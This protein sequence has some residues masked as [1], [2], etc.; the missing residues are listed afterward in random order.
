VIIDDIIW[1][2]LFSLLMIGF[3][4]YMMTMPGKSYCGGLPKLSSAQLSLQ[5]A[6][7][8]HVNHLALTI[9]ERNAWQYTNLVA[10]KHYIEKIFENLGYEINRQIYYIDDKEFCNIEIRIIGQELPNEIMVIGAHYDSVPG[11]P[12][13]DD[14]ASGIAAL[15]EL[16][17]LFKDLQPKRSIYLVAFVNEEYPYFYRHDMG[18][19]VYARA[20]REKSANI[21]AMFS[22]ESIGYYT[23]DKKSQK[24]PAV[25]KL[26]YPS[27]GNFIAFVG[28]LFSRS[29]VRKIIKLFR[30]NTQF[31][32]EGIAAP[33]WI[34]GVGWSDQ[35]NFWH[36]GYPAVMVTDTVPFRNPHYHTASDLPHTLYY[37]SMARVVDGLSTAIV[38]LINH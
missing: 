33:V 10:A 13:A 18:S 12:G 9:G 23:E 5:K 16:A 14:N 22:L 34:P 35:I 1:L 6:L 38:Q 27:Q 37:E 4:I 19:F 36:F 29:L 2:A 26:F 15:L 21:I 30:K 20:L 3:L 24:Y 32:S 7:E 17:K 11:S 31:P 28:N 8:S 25:L